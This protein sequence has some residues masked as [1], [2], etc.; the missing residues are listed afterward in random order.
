MSVSRRTC[1][2]LTVL[3]ASSGMVL[4]AGMDAPPP[5]LAGWP[6]PARAQGRARFRWLGLHVYDVHLWVP[7]PVPVDAWADHAFALELV[8]AR[9]LAGKAI[10]ERSL[11][12]MRRQGEIDRPR[13]TAWLDAMV[14][15]FPDVAA[16]DRLCG[17]HDPGTA[18]RFFHN[19]RPTA[20]VPDPAFAESFFG[21][22]LS[23][24]TSQPELR[25]ALLG[26]QR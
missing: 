2:G 12:E 14:R 17:V 23:D 5:E 3:A 8:Y 16:G 21:I 7:Q 10:A 4:A 20:D 9:A 24:R 15:A 6:Q 13:A 1:L 18:A 19:G 22:W 25:Q 26:A 11:V